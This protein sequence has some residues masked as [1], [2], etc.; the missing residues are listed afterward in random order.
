MKIFHSV[1]LVTLIY[2]IGKFTTIEKSWDHRHLISSLLNNKWT[3]A[4][5]RPITLQTKP[6]KDHSMLILIL[7]LAGDIELNP[8]PRTKQQ[9]IYQCG[10]CEHPVTWNCEGVC[11]DDCNIWHH[12][13]CIELCSTDYDLLQR[14]NVQWLC[15]KSAVNYTKPD[16]ICGTESWLKGVKPGKNPTQGAIKS[17]EV[18]PENFAAYRNDQGTLGGGVFVLIHNDIIAVEKPELVTKCEIEWVKVQLKDQ[19]ELTIGSFYMPHRNMDDIKEVDKSLDQISN[20]NTNFILTG[21]FNSPDIDWNTMSI[22][23]NAQD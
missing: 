9:S 11:C 4:G 17:S 12:K 13:S 8:G 5:Q 18:F 23:H 14:S 6:N 16:I 3:S 19:N 22:N 7:L 21:D 10:L 2:H 15:C 20:K 1:I